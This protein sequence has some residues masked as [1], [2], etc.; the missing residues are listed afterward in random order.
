MT[1][2]DEH[3]REPEPEP[4][5]EPGTGDLRTSARG[6]HGVQLAVLGFVGLCGVLR[7]GGPADAPRGV[8]VAA[9]VLALCALGAACCSAF[10]VGRAAWPLYLTGGG[11]DDPARTSRELRTGIALTFTAVALLALSAAVSWW[12]S[13]GEGEGQV[14]GLVRV[15]TGTATVC[16]TLGQGGDGV[17]T[18]RVEDRSAA[19]P[20]GDV[21]AVQPV[22]SCG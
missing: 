22:S 6:W 8:Q 5:L 1:S 11:R 16:G 18:I 7:S 4:D 2:G 20:L 3:A 14:S 9:G 17:L 13:G 21:T 19:V 10:L 12:P 15:S